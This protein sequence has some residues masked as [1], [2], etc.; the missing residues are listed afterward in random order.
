M[1]SAVFVLETVR[2]AVMNEPDYAGTVTKAC[3]QEECIEIDRTLRDLDKDQMAVLPDY[4]GK[5][6][7]WKEMIE[8]SM[9]AGLSAFS[10]G[11]RGK[12]RVAVEHN[13]TK[14]EV[15]VEIEV[16]AGGK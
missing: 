3:Y 12:V 9:K 5:G 10:R 4:D 13:G 15:E 11:G 7:N 14:V 6:N 2:A 8:G 1:L 16:K